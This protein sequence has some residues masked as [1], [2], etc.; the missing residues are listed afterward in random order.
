[1]L[2]QLRSLLVLWNVFYPLSLC[3]LLL[4]LAMIALARRCRERVYWIV[5][6][7]IFGYELSWFYY[8]DPLVAALQYALDGQT[9]VLEEPPEFTCGLA[10]FLSAPLT[11]LVIALWPR[12]DA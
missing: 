12:E 9:R 3:W 8:R 7:P 10:L 11:G 6:L 2:E 1:M 4:W 5:G